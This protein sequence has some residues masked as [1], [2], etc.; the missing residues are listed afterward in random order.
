MKLVEKMFRYWA[1][2]LLLVSGVF[3]FVV[4]STAPLLVGIGFGGVVPIVLGIVGSVLVFTLWCAI[5]VV[6]DEET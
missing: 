5:L 4:S 2:I 3:F 1:G 6:L